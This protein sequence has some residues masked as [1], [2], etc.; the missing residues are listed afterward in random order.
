MSRSMLI[1][2]VAAV[3]VLAGVVVVAQNAP[4]GTAVVSDERTTVD[5]P[6]TRVETDKDG[7][8]V[9]APGVD[10]TVPRGK[11]DD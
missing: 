5:A 9:Q 7:T 1:L 2:I 6:G 3:V 11:D 4:Q 10:I 8:R